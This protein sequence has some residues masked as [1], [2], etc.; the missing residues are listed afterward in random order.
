[1]EF[2][3]TIAKR[4]KKKIQKILNLVSFVLYSFVALTQF[5]CYHMWQWHFEFSFYLFLLLL[6]FLFHKLETSHTMS[7]IFRWKV[8]LQHEQKSLVFLFILRYHCIH[9]YFCVSLFSFILFFSFTYPLEC[10]LSFK[11]NIFPISVVCLSFH[12][13]CLLEW[14]AFCLLILTLPIAF[15]FIGTNWRDS[16]HIFHFQFDLVKISKCSLSYNHFTQRN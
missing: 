11:Y 16:F 6:L 12:F 15:Q 3:W 1:M 4:R 9:I 5:P 14:K 13:L 10:F 7:A 8:F 2:I